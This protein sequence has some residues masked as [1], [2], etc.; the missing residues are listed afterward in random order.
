M[1]KREDNDRAVVISYA[2]YC[3]QVDNA[4]LGRSEVHYRYDHLE[5][6]GIRGKDGRLYNGWIEDCLI[7]IGPTDMKMEF[8]VQDGR[9]DCWCGKRAL[10][11]DY[12][13]RRCRNA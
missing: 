6:R 2:E 12:L 1:E 3:Q 4:G 11:N 5:G 13:C 7:A 10:A 9:L 8:T